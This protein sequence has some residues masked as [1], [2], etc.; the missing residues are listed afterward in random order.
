LNWPPD[1]TI[2]SSGGSVIQGQVS[3]I[4]YVI[5]AGLMLFLA[6][7]RLAIGGMRVWPR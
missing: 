4:A 1:G 5:Q 6:E 7:I 2:I 3:A